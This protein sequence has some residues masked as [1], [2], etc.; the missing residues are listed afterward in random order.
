MRHPGALSAYSGLGVPLLNGL[1]SLSSLDVVLVWFPA[2]ALG[3]AV[4][5][6]W[7]GGP[8]TSLLSSVLA[9]SSGVGAVL[10]MKDAVRPL[11]QDLALV[12]LVALLACLVTAVANVLDGTTGRASLSIGI[13]TGLLVA[14]LLTSG[15]LGALTTGIGSAPASLYADAKAMLRPSDTDQAVSRQRFSASHFTQYT[16]E[17][18]LMRTIR[19][20]LGSGSSNLYILG[21]APVEYVLLDQTPPWEINVYNT[22]PIGDQSRVVTWIDRHRPSVVVLD[23]ETGQSFDGVPNVVRIPLVYQKIIT[24]YEPEETLGYFDVLRR[25]QPGEHPADT[26]WLKRLGSVLDLGAIPDAEPPIGQAVPG[27]PHTPVLQVSSD[28]AASPG[29]VSVP[30]SF[31]GTVVTVEFHASGRHRYEIPIDRLWP[32]ALSH[33]VTLVGP[34]SSGWVATIRTGS[35]PGSRLY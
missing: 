4:L 33:R 8:S 18:A 24:S 10:L 3:V 20:L 13:I 17:L 15:E 21:D 32:W 30:L 16:S 11:T 7:V 12:L 1:R 34:A 23:R 28:G 14:A 35:M 2:V 9:A 31:G 27:G 6:R 5:L 25:M 29:L 19:P 26:F 22:S